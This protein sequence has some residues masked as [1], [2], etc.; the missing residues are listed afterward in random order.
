M[1][2]HQKL[3]IKKTIKKDYPVKYPVITL[4]IFDTYRG[5]SK[6]FWKSKM[7]PAD[8][9]RN[10]EHPF[11]EEPTALISLGEYFLVGYSS[12]KIF[13]YDARSGEM[14]SFYGS[15]TIKRGKS[16]SAAIRGFARLDNAVY[17]VSQAGLFET[18]SNIQIN[19]KSAMTID[20]ING[21]LYI[22]PCNVKVEGKKGIH[23]SFHAGYDM[24]D[25]FNGEIFLEGYFV[26]GEADEFFTKH[27][28]V[29]GNKIYHAPEHFEDWMRKNFTWVVDLNTKE[30]KLIQDRKIMQFIEHKGIVYELTLFEKD[31]SS[32]LAKLIETE[33]NNPDKA[34]F[35]Y[36]YKIGLAPEINVFSDAISA[37]DLGFIFSVVNQKTTKISTKII[38][39]LK[40]DN[41]LMESEGVLEVMLAL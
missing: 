7:K 15:R 33:K 22:I 6:P 14:V 12:G 39:H 23:A 13:K 38:S 16:R 40:P 26:Y 8:E 20:E 25:A 2:S 17:D 29:S 36:P 3:I 5:L 18:S 4:H 10:N 31:E 35:E 32:G 11:V 41:P 34:V 9:I 28:I 1:E 37:G 30:K 27:H 21:H 24:M 19:D